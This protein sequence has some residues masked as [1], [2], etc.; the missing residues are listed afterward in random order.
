MTT[1]ARGPCSASAR[2]VASPS[3]AGSGAPSS[4]PSSPRFGTST[5]TRRRTSSGT[6]RAGAGLRT[7]V[8]RALAAPAAVASG[9]TSWPSST[10][11]ALAM[12]SCA[13][14]TSATPTSA[15]TPELTTMVFSPASSTV[16]RARPVGAPSMRCTWRVSTPSSCSAASR[17]SPPSSAP[18]RPTMLTSW[19]SRAAATAWFAPL[20][21]AWRCGAPPKTVSPGAGSRRTP[22]T[23]STLRLP[24]TQTLIRCAGARRRRGP[25]TP[26]RPARRRPSRSPAG[27]SAVE[28]D[29]GRAGRPLAA[30]LDGDEDLARLDDLGP[31]D[32]GHR[33]GVVHGRRGEA[34]LA[35]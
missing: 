12:A 19:P 11:P 5:S 18:T 9:G 4:V 25:R 15:L 31:D 21:P 35:L 1:T 3:V 26:R 20:P 13:D 30:R 32:G 27:G 16:M 6:G 22:T 14:S 29:H 17:K 34:E 24:T 2:A 28:V 7:T 8:P 33:D 23:R 10:T